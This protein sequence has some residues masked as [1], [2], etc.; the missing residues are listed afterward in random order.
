METTFISSVDTEQTG[1]GVMVDRVHLNDGLILIITD[2]LVACY[3]DRDYQL[4]LEPLWTKSFF[5]AK[6]GLAM[7]INVEK[8]IST[9]PGKF[10]GEPPETAYYYEQWLN[11]DGD[12]I[13]PL[14]SDDLDNPDMGPE[15]T[16]FQVDANE[17]E[18]FNLGCGS[19]VV[20]WE[21]SQGFVM[22]HSGFES[23]YDAEHWINDHI[24]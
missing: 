1:G 16:I 13:F 8:Y 18:A 2:E 7:S 22:L 24:K 20:L 6:G 10:E 21:D 23:H 3:S 14:A 4:G 9:G 17:S 11:G 19:Y 15:Y 5:A 12:A